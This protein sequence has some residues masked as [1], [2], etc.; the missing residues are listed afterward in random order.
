M[1]AP[2]PAESPRVRPREMPHQTTVRP[3]PGTASG[4]DV[5]ERGV[6]L[7]VQTALSAR[8]TALPLDGTLRESFKSRDPPIQ[9][10]AARNL[11][12]VDFCFDDPLFRSR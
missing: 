12:L 10:P 3:N 8:E 7:L 6:A 9:R 1:R 5:N 2:R 11:L 4:W